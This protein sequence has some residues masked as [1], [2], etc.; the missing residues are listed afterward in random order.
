MVVRNEGKAAARV[1]VEEVEEAAE[2]AEAAEVEEA[3]T[4]HAAPTA[5]A[6]K[7]PSSAC[8]TF[9]PP[10]YGDEKVANRDTKVWREGP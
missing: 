9:Q 10:E 5:R 8:V 7:S 6:A 2:V 3:S 1:W 4:T